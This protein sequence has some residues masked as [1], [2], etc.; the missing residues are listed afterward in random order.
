MD[1]QVTR[2]S[3]SETFGEASREFHILDWRD[4]STI[5]IDNSRTK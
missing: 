2:N 5:R 1:G 3:K 4:K